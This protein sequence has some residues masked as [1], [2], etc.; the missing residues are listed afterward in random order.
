MTL[1]SKLQEG[2]S[3]I[4]HNY[5]RVFKVVTAIGCPV[6]HQ[7]FIWGCPKDPNQTLEDYL[8][9]EKHMSNKDY[10][11]LFNVHMRETIKTSPS[12]DKFDITLLLLAIKLTCV[13]V[14][15]KDNRAWHTQD[16]SCLEY[17]LTSI[18]DTRNELAHNYIVMNKTQM[19]EKVESLRRLLI[20]TLESARDRYS[21]DQATV[22][23]VIDITNKNINTIRDHP[24]AVKDIN[25]YQSE[26]LFDN[27]KR[28]MVK[29]GLAELKRMY[30]R[31]TIIN[32]VFFVA[33]SDFLMDVGLV[34]S[35][36]EVK[37][38]GRFA[39]GKYIAY[40][41]ILELNHL[42]ESISQNPGNGEPA[43]M[44]ILEGV[45]GSGKTTLTKF[46]ISE[47]SKR[48][49]KFMGLDQFDLLFL[50]ECRNPSLESFADL[51]VSLMPNVSK[52]FRKEDFVGC[53]LDL[54]I[55]VL[56]DGLDELNKSS[57][58]LLREV[59]AMLR[60][61][62]IKI[63]CTSRPEKVQDIYK[64]IPDG[65]VKVH[66]RIT[67]IP[68]NKRVDFVKAYHDEMKKLRR[69]EQDTTGLVE[70]L[71]MSSDKLDKHF[72]FPLNLVLLTYLWAQAP[73][74]VNKVTTPTELYVQLLDLLV[75]KLVERLKHHD[76]TKHVSCSELK[77]KTELFLRELYHESLYALSR[78]HVYIDKCAKVRLR[79]ICSDLHL[80]FKEV[81]SAFM[82]L[83]LVWT[84]SGT[85]ELL[86]FPHK[87]IHDFFSAS[88]LYL[89]ITNDEYYDF[90]IRSHIS[91]IAK[92]LC[93]IY[94]TVTCSP[95]RQAISRILLSIHE[96]SA[97]TLT[98]N[99]Y[100]NI[101]KHLAGLIGLSSKGAPSS[102]SEEIVGLLVQSGIDN[103]ELWLDIL[104]EVKCDVTTVQHI[105]RNIEEFLSGELTIE[106]AK[107]RPFAFLLPH[108]RPS[109]IYIDITD[110]GQR[111]PYLP[112]LLE[113]AT[114]VSCR[115]AVCLRH[116]FLHPEDGYPD[117]LMQAFRK[118]ADQTKCRMFAFL[119]TVQDASLLPP[120]LEQLYL[121]VADEDQARI[122]TGALASTR[123]P[124]LIKLGVHVMAGVQASCLLSLPALQCRPTLYLS[125][126]D[127]SKVQWACEVARA[128]QPPMDSFHSIMFPWSNMTTKGWKKLIVGLQHNGVKVTHACSVHLAALRRVQ[129]QQEQLEELTRQYLECRFSI[130]SETNIWPKLT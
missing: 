24:L 1:L 18:K 98:V 69:S 105:A 123:L 32:P 44:V 23:N 62:D 102:L 127:D 111:L 99:K 15:H 94:A 28:L 47:W 42:C 70:Y 86:S 73:D 71:N 109:S 48:S 88:C 93:N 121:A 52:S 20:R 56:I 57:E 22:D 59:L 46:I 61:R 45:A 72:R 75:E 35:R 67:G 96:G 12:G 2:F 78:D 29:E 89:A 4:D 97:S 118:S 104:S 120:T 100:Q 34:F 107:V 83:K 51:L 80:P 112:G 108:A 82:E 106:D 14:A 5:L 126:V 117:A 114:T 7:V 122:L 119:G 6:M 11:K 41:N 113:A 50:M 128:L 31:I 55:L 37:Q 10:R 95:S 63:L 25:R 13:N 87:D 76:A 53:A 40:E 74:R 65:I 9:R 77:E 19:V 8:L 84:T 81:I 21:I 115:A 101:L 116:F 36:I 39:K 124:C 33:G 30:E 90:V 129:P 130:E 26:L 54:K 103:E 3:E 79:E 92:V 60:T 66:L 49:H 17:L 125:G 64:I 43:T 68:A 91:R 16:D 58:K 85:D 38:A 27:L 110:S